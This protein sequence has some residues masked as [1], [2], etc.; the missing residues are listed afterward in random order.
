MFPWEGPLLIFVTFKT[1]L[2]NTFHACCR[3][4]PGI[5]SVQ[6]MTIGAAHFT[7]KN[8]VMIGKA[9]FHLFIHMTRKTNFGVFPGIDHCPLAAPVIRVDA[10]RAMAHFAA[11]G[12]RFI[13]FNFYAGMG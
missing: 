4:W 7:L 13:A 3:P 8:G 1:S 6:V 10:S 2:I 12:G 5:A 11:L 9:E